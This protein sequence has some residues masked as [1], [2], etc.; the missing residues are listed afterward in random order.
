MMKEDKQ[1]FIE[2]EVFVEKNVTEN[3]IHLK[4]KDTNK[5]IYKQ[6]N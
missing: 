2:N 3:S 1:V 5:L 6:S 4:T